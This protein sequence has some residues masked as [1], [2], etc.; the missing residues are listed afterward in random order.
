[1]RGELSHLLSAETAQRMRNQRPDMHFVNLPDSGHAP[2]LD[3]PMVV[4][5]L[6]RFLERVP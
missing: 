6:D 5:A 4:A 3:E 2:T 1:V